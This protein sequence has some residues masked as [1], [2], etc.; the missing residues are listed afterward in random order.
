MLRALAADRDRRWPTAA[1]LADALDEV[2]AAPARRRNRA[3]QIAGR[4]P[5]TADGLDRATLPTHNRCTRWS[6]RTVPGGRVTRW[7]GCAGTD[8]SFSEVVAAGTYLQ[9]KQ[10]GDTD[11]TDEFIRSIHS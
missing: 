8:V 9:I 7:T 5:G 3:R 2:A 10:V 6:V 11:R 1:A 4:A